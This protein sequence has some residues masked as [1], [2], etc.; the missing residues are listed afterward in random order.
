MHASAVRGLA[1]RRSGPIHQ[2]GDLLD[3]F[4]TNQHCGRSSNNLAD[5][6]VVSSLANLS[7]RREQVRA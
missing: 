7:V 1:L 2:R 6:V 4:P 3:R 5:L